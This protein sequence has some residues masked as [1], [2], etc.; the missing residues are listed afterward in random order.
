MCVSPFVSPNVWTGIK[1]I[2]R[3]DFLCISLCYSHNDTITTEYWEVRDS[4]V[5]ASVSPWD[6]LPPVKWFT[7]FHTWFVG[8]P[9]LWRWKRKKSLY[10]WRKKE[11]FL[12][13]AWRFYPSSPLVYPRVLPLPCPHSKRL[14]KSPT[15]DNKQKSP[16]GDGHRGF[17]GD[18]MVP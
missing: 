15:G 13:R 16:M 3:L 17:G 5:M 8:V 18:G 11:Y 2:S 14:E 7:L 6:S 12:Q 1:K 10:R 9:C 4:L